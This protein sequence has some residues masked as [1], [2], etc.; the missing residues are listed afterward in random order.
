[1]TESSG[2]PVRN[3]LPTSLPR[4]D[5]VMKQELSKD[6]RI[7]PRKLAWGF[8]GSEATDAVR[9]VL[10]CDVFE[11]LAQGWCMAEKLQEYSDPARHPPGERS[12]VYL[13]RHS[14]VKTV[15][16]VLEVTIDPAQCA[17]LRFT[18][19]LA[20]SFR[21]V[22][23][24]IADGRITAVGAGDVDIGVRLKYGNATLLDKESRKLPL[25]ARIDFNAPGLRIGRSS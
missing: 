4:M 25:P 14:F 10:D 24:S 11:L 15:H 17:S 7:D 16:P 18:L 22:A 19:E 23:L 3:L 21:S 20:A 6:S 2:Y 8:I 12:I 1:M 5:S 9:S 13:A